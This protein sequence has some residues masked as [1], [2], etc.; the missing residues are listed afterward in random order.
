MEKID[1]LIDTAELERILQDLGRDV[2]EGYKDALR[3]RDHVATGNLMQSV[4]S[5][6]VVGEHSYEV[7]L[8]LADYWRYL[9]NG[10]PAHW[11]PRSVILGWIRAKNLIPRPGADGKIPTQETLAFLIARA[12][13]GKS[14]NQPLLR[15]PHG[16]TPATRTLQDTID[17]VLPVYKELLREA[18]G[19]AYGNYIRAVLFSPGA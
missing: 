2:A 19:R 17:A 11:P 14:P 15:N 8:S 5:Q 7:T 4:T 3:N 1:K 12:M 9:E 13:A 18:L 10:T 16:G 6:V